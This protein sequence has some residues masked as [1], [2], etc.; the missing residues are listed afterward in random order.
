MNGL[1]SMRAAANVGRGDFI[2]NVFEKIDG[3]ALQVRDDL[4]RVP[5]FGFFFGIRPGHEIGRDNQTQGFGADPRAIGNDEITETEERFVFLP[6]GNVEKGVGANHEKNA[7]AMAMIDMTKVAN[8]VHGIVELGAAEVFSGFG[9]RRIGGRYEWDRRN[10]QRARYVE[11]G[12]WRR[13]GAPALW[14]TRL[15]ESG[16]QNPRLFFDLLLAAKKG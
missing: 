7:V 4:R 3:G 8:G 6:H 14:S 9:E 12:V 10:R 15:R 2:R 11:D 13:C 1:A 5:V 16:V